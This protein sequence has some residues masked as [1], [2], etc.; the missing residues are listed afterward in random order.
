MSVRTLYMTAVRCVEYG[1]ILLLVGGAVVV[2]LTAWAMAHD[3]E[4]I[5]RLEYRP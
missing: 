1:L 2:R 5:D 3:D 4:L